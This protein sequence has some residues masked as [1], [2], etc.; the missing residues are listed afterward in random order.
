MATRRERVPGLC[1]GAGA[2]AG[3]DH[4]QF[5]T[6]WL[7]VRGDTGR[8][9]SNRTK[10]KSERGIDSRLPRAIDEYGVVES[11]PENFPRDRRQTRS[12]A[13]RATPSMSAPASMLGRESR[14]CRTSQSAAFATASTSP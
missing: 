14:R 5:D 8:R 9:E 6:H 4:D 12:A 2:A 10:K 1:L 13:T 3:E 11:G 7:V